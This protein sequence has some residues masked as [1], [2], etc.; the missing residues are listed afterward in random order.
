[1]QPNEPLDLVDEMEWENSDKVEFISLEDAGLEN[2][3][4]DT[5]PAI[6]NRHYY[7]EIQ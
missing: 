7:R 2:A 6:L 3:D 5:I 1:M 4:D